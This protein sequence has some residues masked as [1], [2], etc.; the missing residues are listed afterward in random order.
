MK[1]Y[2]CLLI[3]IISFLIWF[4][5]F[6]GTS[7][8]AS[9]K[10]YFETNNVNVKQ[11]DEFEMVMKID[12]AGAAVS[13][14]DAVL[15][16]NPT[17]LEVILIENGNFFPVF[18]KHFELNNQKI[19]ITGFFSE[20]SQTKSGIGNFAKISFKAVKNGATSLKFVCEEK[21]LSDTNIINLSGNDLMTCADLPLNKITIAGSTYKIAKSSSFGK[22]L[23]TESGV[24]TTVTPTATIAPTT[25]AT[26]SGM[27]E[28]G[29]F[30]N[31]AF[32][33]ILGMIFILLGGYLLVYSRRNFNYQTYY[34]YPT[35]L[36]ENPP[37][38]S[39]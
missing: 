23:G 29:V 1:K 34:S 10:L 11:G 18:G 20:K 26:T 37:Q 36:D 2:A 6:A 28:T 35:F 14:A 31:A 32:M 22:I 39:S 5:A 3:L 24:L 4:P 38:F 17:Y 8:A 30:D 19:Y 7:F 25:A 33:I 13:G 12:T 21:S 27:M 9:P 16:Y 15:E